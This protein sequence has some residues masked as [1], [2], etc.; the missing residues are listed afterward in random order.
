MIDADARLAHLICLLG[1]HS[2]V[3]DKL[4]WCGSIKPARVGWS[5][6]EECALG[7]GQREGRQEG[8]HESFQEVQHCRQGNEGYSR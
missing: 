6:G 5:R 2:A 8:S 7:M 4:V 3:R 1:C